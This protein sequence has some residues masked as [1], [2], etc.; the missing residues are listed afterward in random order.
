MKLPTPLM[1]CCLLAILCLAPY[2]VA[3]EANDDKPLS[4]PEAAPESAPGAEKPASDTPPDTRP[5][6]GTIVRRE[7][8]ETPDSIKKLRAEEEARKAEEGTEIE[9][10]PSDVRWFTYP[11]FP[12]ASLRY[13]FGYDESD[14]FL[15]DFDFGIGHDVPLFQRTGDYELTRSLRPTLLGLASVGEINDRV[16][17]RFGL[18][19]SISYHWDMHGTGGQT[20]RTEFPYLR[21]ADFSWNVGFGFG[22]V[23][24]EELSAEINNDTGLRAAITGEAGFVFLSVGVSY[25]LEFYEDARLEDFEL[26]VY[27]GQPQYYG[28]VFVGYRFLRQPGERRE[29][30]HHSFT[31][32]FRILV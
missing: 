7:E 3:Q 11:D 8:G 5:T 19:P 9:Y 18:F 29:A 13:R 24:S 28:S 15:H 12:V 31:I 6:E 4:A 30:I 27:L 20:V 25:G 10:R 22:P 21:T 26:N 17:R 32:G 14:N 23:H 2:L 1:P 16:A